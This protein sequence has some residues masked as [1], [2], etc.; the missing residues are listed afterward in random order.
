MIGGIAIGATTVTAS[1]TD[2]ATAVDNSNQALET[3]KYRTSD[4]NDH[5]RNNASVLEEINAGL[6]EIASSANMITEQA[7]EVQEITIDTLEA[8][9]VGSA[10][11]QL[12]NK[13]ILQVQSSSDEM[14]GIIKNLNISSNE[15]GGIINIIT[16]ISEQVNLLALNAAIEAARAGEHGRGFA[17]VADEVRKLA[18]ET[19]VSAEDITKLVATLILESDKALASVESERKQ[20]IESVDKIDQTNKEFTSILTKIDGVASLMNRITS[21]VSSQTEVTDEIA[22]AMTEI[23]SSTVESVASIDNITENIKNQVMIFEEI[24]TNIAALSLTAEALQSETDKF[25]L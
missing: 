18:E 17:V 23:T 7:H 24:T 9:K 1:V 4:I 3:I 16:G 6:E 12:V 15:I 14:N 22:M 19:K 10:N 20:V 11:I 8:S 5:S 13:S 25:K 21:M 2:I